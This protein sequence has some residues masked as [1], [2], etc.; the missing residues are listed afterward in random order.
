MSTYNLNRGL[1]HRL[2]PLHIRRELLLKKRE[3]QQCVAILEGMGIENYQAFSIP[4]LQVLSAIS[5]KTEIDGFNIADA[6]QNQN[7]RFYTKD[8]PLLSLNASNAL[9]DSIKEAKKPSLEFSKMGRQR[10]TGNADDFA[11]RM[12][13]IIS[14]L[15]T[16]VKMSS[17]RETIKVLNEKEIPAPMGGQWHV[18][19]LQDL[20]KRWVELGLSSFTSKPK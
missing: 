20:N 17:Y 2:R 12:H 5:T 8:F 13:E 3:E 15:K 1:A 11:L 6:I 18:R 4:L 10:R 16:E 7:F 9:A 14:K 19:T